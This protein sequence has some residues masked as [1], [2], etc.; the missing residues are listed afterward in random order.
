MKLPIKR[1]H[2]KAKMPQ[3]ETEQAACFDLVATE[4]ERH[5]NTATYGTGLV[6]DIP[7]GYHLK[8]YSRSGHGFK[9][10]LR[11]AN[12]TG[13]IDSDYLG[14][15]K[16]KMVYDGPQYATPDW[17]H[18]G[19]RIAQAMLVKNV[20][21]DLVEVDEIKKQTERGTGGFGSTGS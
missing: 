11:L 4:R 12:S 9:H 15:I 19:D 14:E 5:G 1:I 17:P 18:V 2:P 3:F 20:K 16:V 13:I 10:G 21:T 8:I 7:E 6:M